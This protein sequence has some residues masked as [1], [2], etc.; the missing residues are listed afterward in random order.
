VTV[1]PE[2]ALASRLGVPTSDEARAMV[3]SLRA[4]LWS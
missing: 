1:E 3:L 2:A 4:T